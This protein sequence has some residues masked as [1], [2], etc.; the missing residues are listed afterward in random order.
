[1]VSFS[2]FF[3]SPCSD[4]LIAHTFYANIMSVSGNGILLF[5][6]N[7]TA[8]MSSATNHKFP[9]EFKSVTDAELL[10]DFPGKQLKL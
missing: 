9:F 1:M 10:A 7:R 3:I 8:N 5:Q 2:S 6:I 4:N